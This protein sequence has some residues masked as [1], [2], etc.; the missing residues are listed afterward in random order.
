MAVP[1]SAQDAHAGHGA[2][3]A[4]ASSAMPEICMSKD[5]AQPAADMAPMGDEE[6]DQE[7]MDLVAGMAESHRQMMGAMV[8]EDIDVAFICGMIPHHQAAIAMARAE[9]VH[10]D[11][12][13]AKE[14]AQKII[15]AQEQEIADMIA[16]LEGEGAE[17]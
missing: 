4:T 8:I 1:A 3:D 11:N 7:H 17:E 15:D 14:L 16:W 2:A 9:I 5:E 12:P 6:M 10:G 13:W